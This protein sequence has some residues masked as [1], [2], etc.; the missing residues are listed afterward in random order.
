MTSEGT[1]SDYS[2]F[3][4]I[5]SLHSIQYDVC[6]LNVQTSEILNVFLEY[7]LEFHIQFSSLVFEN[8]RSTDK[9]E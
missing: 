8:A 1:Y 7:F 5:I 2:N 4:I 3:R 9:V 6:L